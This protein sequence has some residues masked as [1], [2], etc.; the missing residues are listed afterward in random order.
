M[1]L[2]KSYLIQL[3]GLAD[4]W[5]KLWELMKCLQQ[6]T[7]CQIYYTADACL[8]RSQLD[9]KPWTRDS[10]SC[11]CSHVR[12]LIPCFKIMSGRKRSSVEELECNL[13]RNMIDFNPRL[14]KRNKLGLRQVLWGHAAGR[15]PY[16]WKRLPQPVA[17]KSLC[18]LATP[19]LCQLPQLA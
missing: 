7:S 16:F 3:A 1:L 9:V 19:T 15:C 10:T 17:F 11:F 18:C 12:T 14:V 8:Q 13:K 4:T 6:S 5:T 2:T